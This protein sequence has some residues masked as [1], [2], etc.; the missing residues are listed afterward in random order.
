MMRALILAAL[1]ATPAM[2]GLPVAA[3]S[4]PHFDCE[5][6]PLKYAIGPLPPFYD[7]RLPLSEIASACN[8]FND[9]LGNGVNPMAGCAI[10]GRYS[11]VWLRVVPSDQ[12]RDLTVCSIRH[13]NAHMRGWPADHPDA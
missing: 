7:L 11:G 9:R 3:A 8:G 1:V 2:A 5:N 10:L 12:P 4:E 13:E 6:P